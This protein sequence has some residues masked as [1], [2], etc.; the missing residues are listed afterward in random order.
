MERN[1]L[2]ELL[3]RVS[4]TT[5]SPSRSLIW[6]VYQCLRPYVSIYRL[7]CTDTE[8]I[9]INCRCFIV[10]GQFSM[11][12]TCALDRWETLKPSSLRLGSC[13]F[14]CSLVCCSSG[15]KHR[16]VPGKR[17]AIYRLALIYALWSIYWKLPNILETGGYCSAVLNKQWNQWLWRCGV[18]WWQSDT[19]VWRKRALQLRCRQVGQKVHT[20]SEYRYGTCAGPPKP[21]IGKIIITLLRFLKS[22]VPTREHKERTTATV[23]RPASTWAGRFIPST[24]RRPWELWNRPAFLTSSPPTV[25]PCGKIQVYLHFIILRASSSSL[26]SPLQVMVTRGNRTDTTSLSPGWKPP[27]LTRT[28]GKDNGQVILPNHRAT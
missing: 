2:F 19:P 1:W 6:Q 27:N 5:V 7:R 12:R 11:S 22:P 23:H 16:W 10:W 4:R 13:R 24:H 26:S 15:D 17:C 9:H 18:T 21:W 8:Y 14:T 3:I 20:E 28:P 25:Y